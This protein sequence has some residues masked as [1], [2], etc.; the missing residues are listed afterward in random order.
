M[1]GQFSQD[2]ERKSIE[3]IALKVVDDQVRPL[4][5]LVSDIIWDTGRIK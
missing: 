4:Q 2:I 3:P 1:V 5:R